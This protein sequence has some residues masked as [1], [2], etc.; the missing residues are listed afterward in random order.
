MSTLQP[1]VMTSRRVVASFQDYEEAQRAVDYLSDKKF[2][3]EHL[4]IVGE[5]FRLV[6]RTRGRLIWWKSTVKGLLN[7]AITG[8]LFGGILGLLVSVDPFISVIGLAI[9]GLCFGAFIGSMLGSIAYA[10]TGESQDF[11]SI[12][13]MQAEQYNILSDIDMAD[14]AQRLLF[15]VT[16]W[17]RPS[18][19]LY[20]ARHR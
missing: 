14:E 1:L 16:A 13:N 8:L 18:R 5:N 7:G 12:G 19:S 15:R 20:P 6:E 17:R 10:L 9:W 11:I 3:V 4:T 2:P